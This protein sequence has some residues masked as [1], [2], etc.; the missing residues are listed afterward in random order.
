MSTSAGLLEEQ[1]CRIHK[2]EWVKSGFIIVLLCI[3]CI[4]LSPP[5][6]T[7]K[8]IVLKSI[9]CKNEQWKQK[10]IWKQWGLQSR[11]QWKQWQA[12]FYIQNRSNFSLGLILHIVL[13]KCMPQSLLRMLVNLP[14]KEDLFH[15]VSRSWPRLP[16]SVHFHFSSSRKNL[17]VGSGTFHIL[18]FNSSINGKLA[19]NTVTYRQARHPWN[20]Q[21]GARLRDWKGKKRGALTPLQ[22]IWEL[23][24]W[25]TQIPWEF[26]L[27]DCQK[28]YAKSYIEK[29]ISWQEFCNK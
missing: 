16:Q 25:L 14:E 26:D 29:K 21:T 9:D 22:R 11:Q 4:V 17:R 15:S 1:T 7:P 8:G 23:M 28:W 20:T 24:S 12:C 27:L 3:Y 19:H 10:L 18:G 6:V 5:L 2:H 13:F